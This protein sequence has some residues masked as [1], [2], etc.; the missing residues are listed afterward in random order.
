MPELVSLCFSGP[1]M[2]S[3][4]RSLRAASKLA[5][6]K[7]SMPLILSF[8][9]ACTLQGQTS[10]QAHQLLRIGCGLRGLAERNWTEQRDTH[11][12]RRRMKAGVRPRLI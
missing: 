7:Q 2:G 4:S 3:L 11:R 10:A 1:S 6:L 8:A 5:A 12:G 9:E